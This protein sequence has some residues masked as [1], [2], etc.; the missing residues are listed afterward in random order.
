MVAGTGHFH[1][2]R[3]YYDAIGLCHI[4]ADFIAEGLNA[5]QP[6]VIVATPSHSTQIESLLGARGFDVAALKRSGDLFVK[7]AST[8]LP[9][10]MVDGTPSEV[11]F[12]RVVGSL[13]ETA[14]GDSSRLVRVYGEMVDV[15]WKAGSTG[16]ARQLE[17]LWNALVSNH[18][19]VLLC[20]YALDGITHTTHISEICGH[21]THVVSANGD[22]ARAH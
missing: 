5:G 13:I 9:S 16:A 19:F 3:F 2:V 20:A 8:V 18:A 1:A 15:L 6:A 21:H 12:E 11:R 22:V 7:D 4:V 10:L 17:A 14:R